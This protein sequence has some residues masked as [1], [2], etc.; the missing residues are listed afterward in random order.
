[1]PDAYVYCSRCGTQNLD[2]AQFCQKCGSAMAQAPAPTPVLAPPAP[3]ASAAAGGTAAVVAYAPP[4][5]MV[6]GPRYAGFW[7]RLVAFMLDSVILSALFVPVFIVFLLPIFV[8]A[9][10]QIN[11]EEPPTELFQ[12][13]ALM[14]PVLLAIRWLYEAL[15]TCSTWQGTVGKRVLRLKVTDE[16]GN[17]ISFGR[18]TGRYFSKMLSRAIMSIGFF[19]IGFTDRKRGLHDMIAGTLVIRE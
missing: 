12:A 16:A 13:I 4:V 7:I 6:V 2:T 14:I 19:M 15:T 11:A 17:R 1:M 5:S 18:S 10:N 3:L 8:K 9:M